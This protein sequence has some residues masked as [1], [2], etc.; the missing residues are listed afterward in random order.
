MPEMNENINRGERIRQGALA[1]FDRWAAEY[2]RSFLSSYIRKVQRRIIKE[3]APG[4]DAFVLDVGCGTG[5]GIRYLA[6][7]VKRGLLGGLDLSPR[8]IEAARDKLGDRPGIDLRVGD[9][10]DLP[11]P[12]SHFDLAMS[13]FTIHHFP[14]PDRALA[15]IARVLKPKGQLFLAD[16]IFPRHFQRPLNGLLTL[17][18]GTPVEVQTL[19]SLRTLLI[20]AS[21]SPAL[22]QRLAPLIWLVGSR[23]G[24]PTANAKGTA[25]G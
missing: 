20:E 21:F 6:R 15:E 19:E 4:E 8:M 9:A 2:D 3:M 12:N 17:V 24:S 23:K 13:T 14:H 7:R 25:V 1:S 16:L 10:E 18:E 22:V 5:E 11:W